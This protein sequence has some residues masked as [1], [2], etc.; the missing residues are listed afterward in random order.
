[1]IV[2]AGITS[3]RRTNLFTMSVTYIGYSRHSSCAP[4]RICTF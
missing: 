2:W 4:S 1:V 3:H